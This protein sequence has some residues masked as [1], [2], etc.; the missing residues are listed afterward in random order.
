VRLS[1]AQL[2]LRLVTRLERGERRLAHLEQVVRRQAA[3]RSSGDKRSTWM[4]GA[5]GSPAYGFAPDVWVKVGTETDTDG[6]YNGTAMMVSGVGE[7]TT[8]PD[9]VSTIQIWLPDKGKLKQDSIVLCRWEGQAEDGTDWWVVVGTSGGKGI[10][11]KIT[12]I[13]CDGTGKVQPQDEDGED[14]GSQVDVYVGI[15]P[16]HE[17]NDVVRCAAIEGAPGYVVVDK[18][19]GAA[20]WREPTVPP[21]GITGDSSDTLHN[22]QDAPAQES[23]C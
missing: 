5:P 1:L 16:W 22:K 13:S 14:Q 12:S 10:V 11:G 19:R 18:I 23:W 9:I 6:V 2:L 3:A 21:G 20:L 7:W 4:P 17:V 8:H 15:E